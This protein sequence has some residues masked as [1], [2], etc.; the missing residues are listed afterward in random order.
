M[1]LDFLPGEAVIHCGN[2]TDQWHDE[3]VGTHFYETAG[4]IGIRI[5]AVTEPMIFDTILLHGLLHLLTR[6]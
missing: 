1:V 4:I 6:S 5:T 2:L 3:R